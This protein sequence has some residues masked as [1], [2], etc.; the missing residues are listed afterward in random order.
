M[1]RNPGATQKLQETW[2]FYREF[3]P[4]ASSLLRSRQFPITVPLAHGPS[5]SFPLIATAVW[6]STNI[7]QNGIR[8]LDRFK[9]HR[10]FLFAALT[11]VLPGLGVHAAEVS[12]NLSYIDADPQ[13]MPTPV[14]MLSVGIHSKSTGVQ[15]SA[16]VDRSGKFNIKNV[17]PGRYRLA[18]DMPARIHSMELDSRPASPLDFEVGPGSKNTLDIVLSLASA[19]I[20]VDVATPPQTET[21]AILAPADPMLTLQESCWMN[22]VSG[23]KI[24]WQFIPPGTYRLFIVDSRFQNEV[25]KYGPRLPGFLASEATV[26]DSAHGSTSISSAHYIDASIVEEAIRQAEHPN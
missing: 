1:S 10:T 17:T 20:L 26:I 4:D 19:E 24:L 21:V 11:F 18:L 5:T 13:T 22:K 7:S 23:N 14:E 9:A 16:Q 12:G 2:L 15:F 3:W 8:M 6:G 25:S